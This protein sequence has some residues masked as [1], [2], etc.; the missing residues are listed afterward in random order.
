MIINELKIVKVWELIASLIIVLLGILFLINDS[1]VIGVYFLFVGCIAV[2]WAVVKIKRKP[3]QIELNDNEVRLPYRNRIIAISWNDI[4]L[5]E[6]LE[7]LP[8]NGYIPIFFN[9]RL[10]DGTALKILLP[11]MDLDLDHI[12]NLVNEKTRNA[13]G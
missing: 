10:K 11:Q 1:G 7:G 6:K 3:K 8:R 13:S 4:E 5:A 2:S 12:I 9:L